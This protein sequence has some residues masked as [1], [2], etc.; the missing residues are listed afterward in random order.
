MYY[1]IAISRISGYKESLVE[2]I[3]FEIIFA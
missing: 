2:T 1:K 3:F